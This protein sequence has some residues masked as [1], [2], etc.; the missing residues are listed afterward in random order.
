[1]HDLR[2]SIWLSAYR[3]T[4]ADFYL[5]STASN[6][7]LLLIESVRVNQSEWGDVCVEL[8]PGFADNFYGAVHGAYRG[9]EWCA[10]LIAIGFTRM[11]D[12]LSAETPA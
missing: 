11:Q 2:P 7:L 10:A 5:K 1:M 8:F 3:N 12:R 6:G 4:T 9:G